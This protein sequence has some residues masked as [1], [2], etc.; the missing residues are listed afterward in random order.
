MVLVA[1]V[2]EGAAALAWFS[3]PADPFNPLAILA[4]LLLGLATFAGW[5]ALLV[6]SLRRSRLSVGL[7]VAP[8]L[9]ALVIGLVHSGAAA[10]LRFRLVD[11]AAF[12][13]VVSAVPA[14]VID[15]P[16]RD[17]TPAES[18]DAFE[19]FPG[20]C[21]ARIGTLRI[22][23]CSSF[24]A[25]YLFYDRAGSGVLD[26]GG[27]AYLPAGAPR[28]DVGSGEFEHPQ[29]VRLSGPWYAFSASW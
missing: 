25:G 28:H 20:A 2:I 4:S 17:L 23:R 14:P 5:A 18:A 27:V 7:L 19:D 22:A 12:E 9:A 13:Q 11:R 16:G 10:R 8:V 21:P 6:R 29:F 26:D 3:R 1:V 24:A 15:L